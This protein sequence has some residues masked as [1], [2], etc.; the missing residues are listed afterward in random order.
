MEH[1]I[2]KMISVLGKR[3]LHIP[4][5]DVPKELGALPGW[6]YRKEWYQEVDT[7]EWVILHFDDEHRQDLDSSNMIIQPIS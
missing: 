6:G 3:Y 7:K 1:Y 2:P 4:Q 5:A